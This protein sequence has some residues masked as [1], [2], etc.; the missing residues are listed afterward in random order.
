MITPNIIEFLR[1]ES[2]ESCFDLSAF[3]NGWNTWK[4]DIHRITSNTFSESTLLSLGDNLSKIFL[5]TGSSGR[6]QSQVS[7]GGY[8]WE[9]LVCWYLNLCFAGSRAVAIRK[10]RSLPEALRNSISVNYGS[11][12]SNTESDITVIIFPDKPEFT[13]DKSSLSILDSGGNVIPNFNRRGKFNSQKIIDPLAAKYFDEFEL[14]IIQCKTNWNDNAQI[15]MLWGMIYE[16]QTFNNN[17]ISIGKNGFSIQQIP[18]SYS[19]C[20]VP[21]NNLTSYTPNSTSVHRVRNLSGGNY[22]G[23]PAKSGISNSIKEIFNINYSNAFTPNQRVVLKS[24]L[25][26]LSRDLKYFDII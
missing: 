8:G 16:A 12:T 14:G 15:P 13:N 18:F 11:F 17:S 7:G 21:T 6:N 9:G 20:T 2:V 4:T 1:Q 5:T 19:F 3:V 25:P 10:I 26:D 22:W 23:R 24:I